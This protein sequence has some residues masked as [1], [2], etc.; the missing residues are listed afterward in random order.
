[1]K[2]GSNPTQLD[3]VP[4][5]NA[6]AGRD[7]PTIVAIKRLS[8]SFLSEGSMRDRFLREAQ[9]VA[10]LS[11]IYIVKL[12]DFDVKSAE[13]QIVMEYV[14]GPGK[15]PAPDWPPL[16]LNLEQKLEQ[17]AAPLSLRFSV[18]LVKKLCA[19]IEYAHR[20]GVIHRDLKPSNILL[21]EHGEP[22]IVDFGI[23]RQTTSDAAKL[24]MTANSTGRGA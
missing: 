21:D 22:R 8:Q 12:Y 18:V 13:P 15:A 16:S 20:R 14:A 17:N 11:H 6:T 9:L 3:T 10:S 5:R 19:A 7:T 1:M 24:T 4:P 2:T 23:A